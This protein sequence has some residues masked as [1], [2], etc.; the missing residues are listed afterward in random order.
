MNKKNKKLIS[1]IVGFLCIVVLALLKGDDLISAIQSGLNGS[2][3]ATGELT[4]TITP[5]ATEKAQPTAASKPTD[6]LTPTTASKPTDDPTTTTTPK[7]TAT[8]KPTATP[9]PTATT[10]P[11]ATP[12][13][14]VTPKPTST[15]KPTVT[16][17]PTATPKPT[18]KA[19]LVE[20]NGIY[21]TTDLVAAYIHTYNKLPSNY[22]TKKEAEALG[23]VSNKGN[24]WEVT[25]HKCIGGDTFG[26]YEGLLPKQK[27]RT[28]KECDVNYNG[29]YRG[30]ERLLFSNDGLIYYTN[31][32]YETFTKLY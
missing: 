32:H 24:L 7:P 3:S 23:W 1:G 8:T 11:T 25:D 21:T 27:G 12:K 15:P 28:W 29:G 31:D 30:T 10:K 13:P 9:K 4:P 2:P 17:K 16:P 14:T 20:E 19:S 6:A 26:N 18:Q 22:I 5:D